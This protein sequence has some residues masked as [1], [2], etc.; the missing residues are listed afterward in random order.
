MF[1]ALKCLVNLLA[2]AGEFLDV[3]V[4]LGE[5]AFE[6][7]DLHHGFGEKFPAFFRGVAEIEIIDHRL[8]EQFHLRAELRRAFALR[9]FAAFRAKLRAHTV[10]R[11]IEAGY[12]F[13]DRRGARGILDAEVSHHID[14]HLQFGGGGIE[15]FGNRV[16]FRRFHQLLESIPAINNRR[17]VGRERVVREK[18]IDR[19]FGDGIGGRGDAGVELLDQFRVVVAEIA[20]ADHLAAP[21][22]EFRQVLDEAADIIR[23][24]GAD[25]DEKS[26]DGLANL[27][28]AVGGGLAEADYLIEL[29]DGRVGCLM[30]VFQRFSQRFRLVVGEPEI[31]VKQAARAPDEVDVEI[32][33]GV[34]FPEQ[35]EDFPALR[36]AAHE[37]GVADLE[38]EGIAFD[39]GYRR[40]FVGGERRL[41]DLERVVFEG[42]VLG[43]KKHHP[44]AAVDR[45]AVADERRADGLR[46]EVVGKK[47]VVPGAAL[48]E[49]IKRVLAVL[50]AGAALKTHF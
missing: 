50:R 45:E 8:R 31:P 29:L 13:D 36:H 37:V 26:F 39:G 47:H 11:G 10:E 2:L 23:R 6:F 44:P 30:D 21:L 4:E 32:A 17:L 38:E 33:V 3:V 12:A 9:E 22:A 18:E 49:N 1:P 43:L 14:E 19:L 5:T 40:T 16:G 41:P 15:I 25:A 34:V 48:I 7:L 20:Q 35:G 42:F 46:D 27:G 24:S 28:G